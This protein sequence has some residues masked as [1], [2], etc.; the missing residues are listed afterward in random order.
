MTHGLPESYT[1]SLPEWLR[2]ELP[3]LPEFLEGHE[4]QMALVHRL[5]RRNFAEG[6]GGPFAAIVVERGTGRLVSLGVNVVLGSQ[7]S[8]SHAEV[9]ALGLAQNAVGSWNLRGDGVVRDL[10][11]N[12]RPCVQCYGATF[13]SGAAGLVIAGSGPEL[14]EITTFDE[15]PVRDDWREQLEQRGM[16]VVSDVLRAEAIEVFEEYRAAVDRADV[17]VYNAAHDH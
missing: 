15:G 5:A 16:T 7:I 13:W 9:V 6:N 14:E 10:I 8:S 1:I 11:V 12:W 3:D 4:A 2:A 17:T